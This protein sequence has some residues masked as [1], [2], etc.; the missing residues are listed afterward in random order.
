MNDGLDHPQ[1]GT[2]LPRVTLPATDGTKVCLAKLPGRTVLIVYP[3]TGRPGHPNPPDW[4]T[5]EGAH[6]STPELEGFRNLA[7][8]FT[9]RNVSLCALSLQSTEYQREMVERLK[10]PFP[11]LSDADGAFAKE[12]ALPTFATCGV[13]YLKRLTLVVAGGCIEKAFYP[14]RDPASHAAEILRWL[15]VSGAGEGG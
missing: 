12:L 8:A 14:V 3:W 7:S 2:A 11:V 9:A 5:I 13:S 15:S 10:L 6:G 4:D 1:I